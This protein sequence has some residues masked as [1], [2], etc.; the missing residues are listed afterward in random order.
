V[1]EVSYFPARGDALVAL[2]ARRGRRTNSPLQFGQ[3]PFSVF[4]QVA[5]NVHS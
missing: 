1:F 5:Q 4:A 3:I 2:R